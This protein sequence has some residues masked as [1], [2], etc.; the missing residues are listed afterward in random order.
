MKIYKLKIEKIPEVKGE[1][2]TIYNDGEF[3]Y[4]QGINKEE[5]ESPFILSEL[6]SSYEER[7]KENLE[8]EKVRKISMLNAT[9]DRLLSSFS[10]DAL[11]ESYIYDGKQEDQ[12]N[13]M[14]LVIAGIDG[15]FRCAKADNPTDKQNYPHTKE[16]IKQVYSDGL[17]IKSE[18]IYKCGVLKEYL[19]TLNSIDEVK[20]IKWEDYDAIKEISKKDK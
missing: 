19:K 2:N 8:Y 3:V 9:C 10:S 6:P 16:Q 11:G 1:F 7:L 14:G 12:I 13:L 4:V 5:L 20:A 15:F 18:T 17:K